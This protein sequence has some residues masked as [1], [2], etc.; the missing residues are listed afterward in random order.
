MAS[1]SFGD[2]FRFTTWGESHGKAIG[3]V[4][5]GV[6]AGL[7]VSEKYI[8]GFLDKRRPGGSLFVSPR[9]EPDK[10]EILSGVYEGKTTGA[11]I[12]TIIWNQ[13]HRP[14][15]YNN[16]SKNFRK[17]HGDYVYEVKY[18]IRDPRGGGRA[19]ARETASRVIA[20]AIA[21][22]IISN[23]VKICSSI[24][25]I[26]KVKAESFDYEFAKTNHLYCPDKNILS[27]W[28]K[29]IIECS[30]KRD[31][32]GGVGQV[33][34]KNL[35]AGFG[36]PIYRKLSARLGEAILSINSIKGVEFGLGFKGIDLLGSEYHQI[37]EGGID[38]G[39]SNG[40][41]IVIRFVTK[42]PSSI[43]G[44]LHS[45]EGVVKS[46]QGR[47]DPTTIIR[48]IPVVE[49]MCYCVLADLKLQRM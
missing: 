8:Q 26:G 45:K 48:A 13:D 36:E 30:Q 18:G 32:L 9:N 27:E 14:L 17:G 10:I 44:N 24:I 3:C 37:D 12:S 6:P 15:D 1:N 7:D 21:R 23:K 47:H 46:K 31:S 20:G 19:S 2:F 43:K 5:D 4:I 11:P 29:I 22:K 16:H 40:K 33:V 41:D 35:E 49:A 42:P 34:I 39:I 25:Q 38:A 28:E